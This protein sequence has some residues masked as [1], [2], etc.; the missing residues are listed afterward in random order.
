MQKLRHSIRNDLLIISGSGT[1]LVLAAT[2]FGFWLAWHSIH[3]FATE[4]ATHKEDER[5]VRLM[6]LDFKRQVQEWKDTLLRGSDPAA[7][8]KYWGNFQAEEQKVQQTAKVLEQRLSDQ[9]EALDLLEE[10]ISAHQQMSVAY[11]KGLQA[12]KN[13][14]YDGKVGDKAVSG[15]DRAPTELLTQAADSI[16]GAAEQAAKEAASSGYNGMFLSL[17]LIGAAVAVA[18]V[19]FLWLIQKAIVKPA[20]QLLQ[21]FDRLAHGNFAVPVRH[22]ARGELGKLAESAEQIRS[23]L[24]RLVAEVKQAAEAVSI[25]ASGLSGT[26][27]HVALSSQQQ[28]EAATAAA[29]AIEEITVSIASVAEN[30]EE[31]RQLSSIGLGRTQHGNESL[32]E[33]VGEIS[34]VETAV[35]EI[36]DS[37]EQFVSSADAITNMTRQ[38]KDIAEQTNLLAL[39]AAIEAARAGEQGRGFAVVADEVRK[40]AEKSAGAASEIDSVTQSLGLQSSTAEQSIRKGKE[41]LRAGNDVLENVAAALAE[42]NSSVSHADQGVGNITASVQEQKVASDDIARHVEKI[43]Q[44]AEENRLEIDETAREAQRLEQLAGSLQALTGKF[45]V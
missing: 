19:L 31:V 15:I 45:S 20:T 43:A 1:I 13:S 17:G 24:G 4:V 9:P 16:S 32:S 44:M 29:A 25:A 36:S 40:L 2:L 34:I 23:S 27:G 21:D 35:E 39:N 6:Q 22:D 42:A 37:V 12:F 3:R 41:S 18:F 33:L 11:R 30:A 5:M 26:A 38:V 28:S 10:F 14:H 7:L 8:D